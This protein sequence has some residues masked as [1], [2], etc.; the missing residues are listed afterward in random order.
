MVTG[1]ERWRG[2]KAGPAGDA[3]T[4]IDRPRSFKNR[5]YRPKQAA[6]RHL[7]PASIQR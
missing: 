4:V 5:F 6:V 2:I 7:F 1:E 3:P